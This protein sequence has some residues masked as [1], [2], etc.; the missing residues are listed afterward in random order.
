MQP[1]SQASE[2]GAFFQELEAKSCVYSLT[3]EAGRTWGNRQRILYELSQ[4][5]T[6]INH[7]DSNMRFHKHYNASS[8]G[9]ASL[10]LRGSA[11]CVVYHSQ[12]HIH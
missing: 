3:E 4:N 8:F 12:H 10:I 2:I 5:K 6:K 1:G 7:L 11:K 9:L